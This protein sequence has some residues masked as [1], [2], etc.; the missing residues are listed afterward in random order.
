MPNL[1][2]CFPLLILMSSFA[3]GTVLP[4]TLMNSTVFQAT[5]Q[6][7][8]NQGIQGKAR[9][10]SGDYMPRNTDELSTN[11][12]SNS[13]VQTTIW[14]FAARIPSNQSSRWPIAEAGHH[15][16]LVCQVETNRHGY[17][18]AMLPVG[19]YTVFAQYGDDLYLNAFQSDG[20]YRSVEVV[21]NQI[22]EINIA[23]TEN[24]VF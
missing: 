23:H 11:S 13:A 1:P 18:S 20:S 12:A 4:K 19:E 22:S 8:L 14:I 7:P 15:A 3:K 5:Q 10:L 21:P 9:Q 16:G 24:A 2:L 17:Y 6:S